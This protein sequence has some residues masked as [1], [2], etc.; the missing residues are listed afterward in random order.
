MCLLRI[1][2]SS[3]APCSC[4]P[5]RLSHVALHVWWDHVASFA[6]VK[7]TSRAFSLSSHC[8]GHSRW[9]DTTYHWKILASCSQS[10]AFLKLSKE[11]LLRNLFVDWDSAGWPIISLNQR[12]QWYL[13]F[14]P[15]QRGPDI[16]PFPMIRNL[17]VCTVTFCKWQSGFAM[18]FASTVKHP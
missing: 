5:S 15:S 9:W 1:N 6:K 11:G 10:S 12:G 16:C 14:F 18:T 17:P 2:L 3:S 8:M 13:P 7:V 4:V